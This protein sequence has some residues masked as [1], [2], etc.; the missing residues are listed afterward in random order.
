MSLLEIV[1][2]DKLMEIQNRIKKDC[3]EFKK[4]N[5]GDKLHASDYLFTENRILKELG[6]VAVETI[7]RLCEEKQLKGNK[8]NILEKEL[9]NIN[10]Y[11]EKKIMSLLNKNPV[12]RKN[13]KE[14]AKYEIVKTLN[15]IK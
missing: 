15:M 10:N 14:R 9:K 13:G 8:V 3:T 6:E 7:E 12:I 4:L 2:K 5:K 11:D 1:P